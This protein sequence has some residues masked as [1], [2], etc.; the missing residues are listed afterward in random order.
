[1]K[2]MADN[3]PMENKEE[4]KEQTVEERIESLEQNV[5][6]LRLQLELISVHSHDESGRVVVPF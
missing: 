3:K 2:F 1:M 6:D 4:N 5:N